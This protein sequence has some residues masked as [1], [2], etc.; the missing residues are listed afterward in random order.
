MNPRGGL[1]AI[2]CCLEIEK[3]K[4][5][6]DGRLLVV[7][8]GVERFRIRKI[9]AETPVLIAEVED[10]EDE[11]SVPHLLLDQPDCSAYLDGDICNPPLNSHTPLSLT[12]SSW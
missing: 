8:R 12:L 11:V 7:M 5:L 1:A 9:I 4:Q 6:E 3:H 10:L 2:G